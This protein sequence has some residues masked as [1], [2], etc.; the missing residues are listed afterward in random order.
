MDSSA[1]YR[2]QANPLHWRFVQADQNWIV[3]VKDP[4]KL[5]REPG[6]SAFV[7]QRQTGNCNLKKTERAGVIHCNHFCF[8]FSDN[9]TPRNTDVF[10]D[11]RQ[12]C[13]RICIGGSLLQCCRLHQDN[14]VQNANPGFSSR[15]FF[16]YPPTTPIHPVYLLICV[17]FRVT[18]FVGFLFAVEVVQAGGVCEWRVARTSSLDTTADPSGSV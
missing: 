15:L 9:V 11:W 6:V 7:L 2:R 14:L 3:E 12:I 17:Q 10:P 13:S 16:L 4:R 5:Q 1:D 8:L 18:G